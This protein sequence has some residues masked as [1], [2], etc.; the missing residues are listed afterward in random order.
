MEH[1][2]PVPPQADGA[3]APAIAIAAVTAY[4]IEIGNVKTT[5]GGFQSAGRCVN[6]IVAIAMFRP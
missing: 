2:V 6:S 1:G 3:L 4:V 5:K